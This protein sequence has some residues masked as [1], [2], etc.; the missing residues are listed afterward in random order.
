MKEAGHKSSPMK[1][2]FIYPTKRQNSY[3]SF[4]TGRDGVYEV[5][6]VDMRKEQEESSRS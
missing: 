2:S 4:V 3:V 5:G 6:A 1:D